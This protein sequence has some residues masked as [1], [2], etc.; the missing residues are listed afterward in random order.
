MFSCSELSRFANFTRRYYPGPRLS[1]EL[2]T[3]SVDLLISRVWTSIFDDFL[4]GRRKVAGF[5]E[6]FLSQ[7]IYTMQL[8]YW[9]VCL[10]RLMA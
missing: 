6:A 1:T 7:F 5:F 3:D 2:S 4:R 8:Q 10:P 9:P